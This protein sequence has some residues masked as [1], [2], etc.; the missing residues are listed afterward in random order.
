MLLKLLVAAGVLLVPVPALVLGGRGLLRQPGYS[1]DEPADRVS[2]VLIVSLR[3]LV[4]L[5]VLLLSAVT[6][7]SAVGAAIRDVE[8]HG[9]VYVF[10]VLDLLLA[11]LVLLSFGRRER[12]PARRRANP[13]PR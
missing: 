4:L 12:R 6:L 3:A 10:F 7:V 5:M 2:H 11:L 9:L 8:L 1:P 13:A